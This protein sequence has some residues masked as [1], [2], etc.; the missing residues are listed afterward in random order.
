MFTRQVPL[1]ISCGF[2]LHR[3]IY[4][5]NL[6]PFYLRYELFFTPSR[7]N[8]PGWKYIFEPGIWFHFLCDGKCDLRYDLFL[9]DL[10]PPLRIY[11]FSWTFRRHFLC[12]S[13]LYY[14]SLQIMLEIYFMS[15]G[16][17]TIFFAT[18]IFFFSAATIIVVNLAPCKNSYWLSV[19]EI[20]PTAK[21]I[22]G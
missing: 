5:R 17:G 3:P 19:G 13:H 20:C 2:A 16:L 11:F 7:S 10:F 4:S 6:V 14:F 21:F 15:P 9:N 8:S 12:I 1:N 18:C 22:I